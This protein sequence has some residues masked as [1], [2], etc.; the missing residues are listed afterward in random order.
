[1]ALEEL[2]LDLEEA[3]NACGRRIS[4]EKCQNIRTSKERRTRS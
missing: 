3:I 4:Q 1:M 2:D